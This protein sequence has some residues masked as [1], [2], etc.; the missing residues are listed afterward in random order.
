MTI[1]LK[2]SFIFIKL[3][4]TQGILTCNEKWCPEYRDS[5]NLAESSARVMN[6]GQAGPGSQQTMK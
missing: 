4:A 2:K 5:V 3:L 6:L 1:N